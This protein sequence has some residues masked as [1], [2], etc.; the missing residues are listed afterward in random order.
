M[1]IR[2]GNSILS[3]ITGQAG[4]FVLR[5]WAVC[6]LRFGFLISVVVLRTDFRCN[7]SSIS[8]SRL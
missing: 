8:L 6:L 3:E 5:S 1:F 7:L 2:I 4:I